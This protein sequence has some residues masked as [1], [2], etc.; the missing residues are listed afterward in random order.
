MHAPG[1]QYAAYRL[2]VNLDTSGLVSSAAPAPLD[3]WAALRECGRGLIEGANGLARGLAL[4]PALG[5]GVDSPDISHCN[6]ER[7][8]SQSESLERQQEG[9]SER[10]I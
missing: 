4:K 9:T 7:D 1:L 10:R 8:S 2:G 6:V 3:V 5:R